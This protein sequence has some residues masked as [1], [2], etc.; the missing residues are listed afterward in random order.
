M[1]DKS[2]VELIKPCIEGI[3]TYDCRT[4]LNSDGNFTSTKIAFGPQTITL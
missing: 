4:S 3:K 1:E 2:A